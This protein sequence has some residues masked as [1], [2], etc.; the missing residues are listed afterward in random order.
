MRE[1]DEQAL[2]ILVEFAEAHVYLD[3]S[4]TENEERQILIAIE[5]IKKGL[6][7]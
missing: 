3:K 6:N 5:E 4:L 1:F 7:S 2:Q